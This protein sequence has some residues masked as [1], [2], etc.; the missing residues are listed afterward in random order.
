MIKA[1]DIYAASHDGL[2]IILYYYPQAEGCVDNRK[3][4]KIRPDEDDASACIRKYGDCYKVTDF[5]DQG[6]ATSP[7]DICMREEHV[8]FGEA[9]VLLAARYNVSDE[10]KHSVNKPDIRKRPASADEAEGSRFFELEEAFTP[11]QLAILGPR[12][13]QEHCDALH[14]HVAKSISYV[15]NREVTTKYTTPTYPI[16][17]RQWCHSR[18]GRQAGERKIFLQDL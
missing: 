3:K 12:V 6:T 1:S 18:S 7:I 14:W 15:K 10:L 16:L 5:G 8:S 13:K 11:E 9:V 17:M 4:F 2:D